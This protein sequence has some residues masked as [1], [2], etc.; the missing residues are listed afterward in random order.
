M[1]KKLTTVLILALASSA[2]A[3]LIGIE[4]DTGNVYEISTSDPENGSSV[5][6]NIGITGLGSLAAGPD[7]TLYGFTSGTSIL[8][9]IDSSDWSA[10]AVGSIG[11]FVFEGGLAIGPDGMAYGTNQGSSTNALLFSIDLNTA[12]SQVIGSMGAGDI[13]GLEL[14]SDGMLVG[15]ERAGNRLVEIDP[16]NGQTTTLAFI[17]PIVGAL[18]AMASIDGNTGYFTTSGTSISIPGSN[19]L[20]TVDFFTGD[21]A[22]VGSLP[23]LD[24]QGIAALHYRE[25][26]VPL[27]LMLFGSALVS[28]G[29]MRKR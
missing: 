29:F 8:Y 28:L 22:L 21:I 27:P 13:N 26:P 19:E 7:G 24:S 23:T 20:Y 14:R 1:F 15:L 17:D 11:E 2:Q 4:H 5:V 6:G 18:G 10:T 25:V 12:A 3:G 16:T 9:A